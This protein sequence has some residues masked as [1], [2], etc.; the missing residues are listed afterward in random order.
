MEKKASL[1]S[2]DPWLVIRQPIV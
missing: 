1:H 2:F